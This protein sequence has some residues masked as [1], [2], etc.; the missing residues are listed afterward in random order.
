M[1]AI[2]TKVGEEWLIKTNADAASLDVG[3]YNDG[4][5]AIGDGDDLAQIT[6]EPGDGNYAR[7]TGVAFSASASGTDWQFDNDAQVS[8][9][10]AN[11]TGSVDSYFI[12]A[13]FLSAE[14]GD[15]VAQDHL[16]ATGALSQSRDLT[17]IDTLNLAAGSVGA[18][19]E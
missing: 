13:N 11:T 3:L 16:I 4:T 10:V 12:V 2:L 14:A 18:S 9:D 5:D 1:S 7:Q 8:Y 19:L 6:T 17:Q 15:S